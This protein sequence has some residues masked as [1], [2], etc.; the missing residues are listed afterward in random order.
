M[1]FKQFLAMFEPIYGALQHQRS[2]GNYEEV[3]WVPV[4]WGNNS[5]VLKP[6]QYAGYVGGT[7]CAAVIWE[8]GRGWIATARMKYVGTYKSVKEAEDEA[9]FSAVE[10]PQAICDLAEAISE[11]STRHHEEHDPIATAWCGAF[12]SLFGWAADSWEQKLAQDAV[13]R[14]RIMAERAKVI[15]DSQRQI[16][17]FNARFSS[18]GRKAASG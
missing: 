10:V 11:H 7:R 14:E 18:K 8:H 1:K 17:L 12:A 15:A 16:E 4:N 13:E 9:M 2:L 5:G 6:C 3:I